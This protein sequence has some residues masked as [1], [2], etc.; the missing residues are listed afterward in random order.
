MLTGMMFIHNV[1]Q[2][3]VFSPLTRLYNTEKKAVSFLVP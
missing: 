3:I 2:G 1:I